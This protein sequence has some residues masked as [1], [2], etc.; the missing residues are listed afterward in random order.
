METLSEKVLLDSLLFRISPEKETAV[1][2]IPATCTDKIITLYHKCLFAGHQGVIKTYLT[3]S[4]KFFIPNLIH[5]LRSYIEGCHIC[6]LSRNEKLPT[7]HLQTRINPNYTPMSRLSMDLKVMPR[8]HKGH[9]YILCIIDEVMNFLITVPLFQARSEEIGEA[10]IE[11]VI[12][13]FCIPAYIIMDQDSVFMSSLMTYLFHKFN[14]KI[15]TVAPY[16]HQ[17]LQA[18][19]GT[20]SLTCI[21]TKHL[22]NLGQMWT[23]YLSLATLAYNMFNS[24]N[25]GNYS[26][27]E[28]TFGRKPKLLLN[29]DSYPDI[30][31]S[32]GFREYYELL[33]KRIKY[34][35]D[36]LFN[37]KSQR[38]AMINK[39]RENFQYKGG[40]LV[41][42]ISPFTRQFRT[43]SQKIAVKYVGAVVVYKI[44]GPH[45][46]LLMTLDGI[47]LKGIFEHV[48]LKPA[49]I[50]TNHGYV[51]NLV[52]LRQ[53][54]NTDLRFS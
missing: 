19:H 24:P 25:L 2:E 39:D 53:I 13:K 5:Y 23:K 17:S 8:S 33:N 16:N 47:I 48:R 28:L 11:N 50:R 12:T 45:N 1:L 34:L 38:L 20:K 22:T 31:V 44:I 14:I 9:K 21:L 51:Q 10:L 32:R 15:K 36:I 43:N 40:D 46:C 37:F 42:I 49:I 26:Q 54:M 35:Q 41:Y 52:E 4:D 6:Q 7:R 3:I 29:V 30:K 18:E 27:Y